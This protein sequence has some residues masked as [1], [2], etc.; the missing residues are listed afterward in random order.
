MYWI[1]TV[2]IRPI[3]TYAATVWWSKVKFKTS[4]VELSKLQRMACLRITG[5]MKTAPTAAVEV[6]I[7]L[8]LLHLQLEAKARAGIYRLYGSDQLKPKS[9]GF[10][11]AHM[12]QGMKI[13]PTL[14]METD[15]MIPRH[16]YD[17]PFTV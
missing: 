13:E 8:P 9:V 11:Y 7:G 16:V 17:K 6:L 4:K 1:Y 2:A 3:V 14:Q 5:A 15:R 12:T 10:G